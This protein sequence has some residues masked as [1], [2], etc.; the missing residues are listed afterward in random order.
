MQLQAQLV[1]TFDAE[2][3]WRRHLLKQHRD[4]EIGLKESHDTLLRP[5]MPRPEQNPTEKSNSAQ[6]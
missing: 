3:F 4:H 2:L 5:F 6:A 1:G